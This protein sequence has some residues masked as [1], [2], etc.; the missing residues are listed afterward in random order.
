MITLFN[1]RPRGFNI[2]NEAIYL[3][4]KQ[5][6][7]KAFENTVNIV[8]LPAIAH[9]ESEAKAGLS[10]KVIYEMNQYGSGV[11]VGGGN[12]Y[13]NGEI[14]VNIEALK[15]LEIPLM[16]FSLSRGR[17]YNRKGQLVRRTDALPDYIIKSL[18]DKAVISL[19]RDKPTY[20]YLRKIGCH[21][22]SLGGCPTISLGTFLDIIPSNYTE[23]NDSKV[24]ISIRNPELLSIPLY[25]KNQ[26]RMDI[27]NIIDFL[28]KE[29]YKDIFLL[30][31]DHRDISFAATF[32]NI[33]YIYTDD[34][35]RFLSIIKSS[36]LNISYR[37]HST[38][39]GFSFGVPTINISY[40][41]RAI[42]LI[43]TIGMNDWNINMF[44][45][46]DI[47]QAVKDRY[48]NLEKLP[49]LIKEASLI[50]EQLIKVMTSS[51]SKFAEEVIN[52]N[53]KTDKFI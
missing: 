43:D 46:N 23:R 51:L 41:E 42:G 24:I 7:F 53:L 48:R 27:L 39:P 18:N 20:K 8:S 5:L 13:E 12:L 1:I 10:S 32:N 52:Y 50:W 26:V 31:H 36:K 21:N 4:L 11:I 30:C 28:R 38:L 14:D 33:E 17:I 3:A 6:L 9:Y 40:D 45:T 19:A 15:A 49:L 16:L 35:Y 34:V 25:K 29:G 44:E 37:L 47:L 2:G 22:C